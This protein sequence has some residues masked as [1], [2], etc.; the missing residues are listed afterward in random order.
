MTSDDPFFEML[1]QKGIELR[2]RE[3]GVTRA[4]A[5]VRV[6]R[7]R[8]EEDRRSWRAAVDTYSEFLRS[9]G[10]AIPSLSD[11]GDPPG[12]KIVRDSQNANR[13]LRIGEK[14][15]KVLLAIA[16]ATSEGRTIS[17]REIY[18]DQGLDANHVGNVVW[19]EVKSETVKREGE[20]LTM[21]AKGFQ[22]LEKAG[23][24]EPRGSER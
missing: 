6:D 23:V 19:M 3:E 14:R 9:Q 20:R 22:F 1:R 10:R 24:W 5:Q 2:G 11:I 16:R 17:T 13:G 4:E 7:Q 21:T 8:L 12:A 18:V 15:L